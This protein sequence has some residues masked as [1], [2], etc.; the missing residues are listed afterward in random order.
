MIMQVKTHSL[1]YGLILI[2]L[3]F[4]CQPKSSSKELDRKKVDKKCDFSLSNLTKLYFNEKEDYKTIEEDDLISLILRDTLEEVRQSA[5]KL[6]I[7]KAEIVLPFTLVKKP[8]GI[9]LE[10]IY[11]IHVFSAL[12]SLSFKT[13]DTNAII[14]IGELTS[15][16]KALN[17]LGSER[18][19][20]FYSISLL[21]PIKKSQLKIIFDDVTNRYSTLLDQR[22]KNLDIDTCQTPNSDE[23]NKIIKSNMLEIVII[24]N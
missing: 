15:F 12:D 13:I 10:S 19:E 17:H 8:I 2:N 22:F 16:H 23:L 9:P 7:G 1:I 3:L 11:K 20:N 21:P 24:S 4:S 5:V 14:S 18:N 6:G